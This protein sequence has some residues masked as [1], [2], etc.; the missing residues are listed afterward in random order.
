MKKAFLV[1]MLCLALSVAFVGNAYAF[2]PKEP[3]YTTQFELS[4]T[5]PSGESDKK[6]VRMDQKELI[7]PSGACIDIITHNENNIDAFF[8]VFAPNSRYGHGFRLPVQKKVS[9]NFEDMTGTIK[10][11]SIGKQWKG[12]W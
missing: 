8:V 12:L 1:I 5:Y 4:L 10:L 11:V 9:L 3:T 6:T 2:I 7:L